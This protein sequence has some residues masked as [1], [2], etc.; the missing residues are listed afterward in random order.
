MWARDL[1]SPFTCSINTDIVKAS[2][3]AQGCKCQQVGE[4]SCSHFLMAVDSVV[5]PSPKLAGR[6]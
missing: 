2:Q 4:I 5:K 3:W 1:M 6:D